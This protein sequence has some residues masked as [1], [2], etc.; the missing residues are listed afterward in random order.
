MSQQRNRRDEIIDAAFRL[1]SRL[2]FKKTTLDEVAGEV[3]IVKSALYR[4]FDN[5]E[6]LF[7]AMIDRIAQEHINIAQDAI[8][9]V[10]GTEN[11]IRALL[12]TSFDTCVL[13]AK[14]TSMPI[15]VWNEV[16]PH[17]DSRVSSYKSSF[18][19]IIKGVMHLFADIDSV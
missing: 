12:R 15:E 2:G 18:I 13:L 5:K 7:N 9:N 3:G 1:F 19:N 4:Y 17:I 16:K 11:R 8:Q 10:A 6:E 14:D